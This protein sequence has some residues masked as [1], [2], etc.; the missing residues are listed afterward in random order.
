MASCWCRVRVGLPWTCLA[1]AL[2]GLLGLLG[3]SC[4]LRCGPGIAGGGR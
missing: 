1:P 2:S 3:T 4:V